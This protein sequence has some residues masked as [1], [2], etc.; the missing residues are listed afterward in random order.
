MPWIFVT[1]LL[2]AS[3]LKA[4]DAVI[5][6]LDSITYRSQIG[7]TIALIKLSDDS[8]WKWIPDAYS[9]NLLRKWSE[10]DEVIVSVVNH[11]GFI[12]QNLSKPHYIPTVALSFNSYPLFPCIENFSENNTVIELSDGSK[13]ELLYDFNKRT[14]FHWSVNDRVIPVKGMHDYFQLINLDI[15]HENRCLIERNVQVAQLTSSSE[16]QFPMQEKTLLAE[17]AVEDSFLEE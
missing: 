6:K 7:T 3:L 10:G 9:E 2:F 5:K 4:E 14:L 1:F 15:P 12:L 11:P 8:V 13:W 17:K 16:D